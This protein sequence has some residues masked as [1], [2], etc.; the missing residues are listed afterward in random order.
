[1]T[2]FNPIWINPRKGKK[3][4]KVSSRKGKTWEEIYGKEKAN[5]M[6]I[7]IRKGT[8]PRGPH[9]EEDKKK[10]SLVHI[11]NEINNT[12]HYNSYYKNG[13]YH[14]KNNGQVWF[15]SSYELAVMK[16]FDKKNIEWIYETEKNKFYL[17]AIDRWYLN[18]FYLTKE[19]TYIQ[20]KGWVKPNDKFFVFQKEYS[21]LNSEMWDSKILK[22]KG[23]L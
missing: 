10:C 3:T 6:R 21:D 15:R 19:D 20:V 5:Y 23:I 17:S 18:D 8:G 9:T 12:P 16:Y 22:D 11:L 13:N 1:M 7:N 2:Y 14:S 4:G